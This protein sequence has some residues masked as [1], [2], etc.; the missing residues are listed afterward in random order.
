MKKKITSSA[1]FIFAMIIGA[2]FVNNVFAQTVPN[3]GTAASF[4]VL[5]GSA[6]TN[7]GPTLVGGNLGVSP[8]SSVTGFPPG[9]VIGTIYAGNAVSAQAQNNAVTA[10]NNLAGQAC[11]TNLT[12][13]LGGL[14]LT[15][16][17]YCL[18][19]AAQLTGTLTLN[20]QGNPN[21]VF[22]FQIGSTLITASNASVVLINGGNACN[23]FF[24]VGSS[25][26]LGTNT[27][28]QGNILAL[29]SITLNTGANLNGRALAVNGAVTTD[30]NNIIGCTALA[31]TAAMANIGGRVLTPS[32]AGLAKARISLTFSSGETFTTMTNSFG[33]YKFT[34]IESGQT[35]VI[36]VTSKRY[37]YSPK[38]L[39]VSE[40]L[41]ESNFVPE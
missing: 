19:S 15:S 35:V 2:S 12:G 40:D 18:T 25:A 14:I 17:T 8:G 39:N 37:R 4:S 26:T 13:Q 20:A 22:I 5:A 7:T 30:T 11:N 27:S 1:L 38:V 6:V 23:V 3:L 24:Q 36:S 41:Y 33:Y 32:S 9:V 31:P 34:G 10:Y 28:F 29:T 16:G 21:A